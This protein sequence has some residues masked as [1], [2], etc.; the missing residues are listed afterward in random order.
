VSKLRALAE[1]EL[2]N[3]NVDKDSVIKTIEQT[4][5][6]LIN[7]EQHLNEINENIQELLEYLEP[8]KKGKK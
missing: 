6:A 8:K 1:K 4:K 7:R 3:L 5:Q 2:A